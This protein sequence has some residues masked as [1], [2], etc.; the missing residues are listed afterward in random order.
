MDFLRSLFA[1]LLGRQ[2][3]RNHTKQQACGRRWSRHRPRRIQRYTR[4]D[5]IRVRR[6]RVRQT[7]G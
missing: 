3:V 1:G 2:P 5:P 7:E 6:R 4:R